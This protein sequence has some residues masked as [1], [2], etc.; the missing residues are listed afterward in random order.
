[1]G[2]APKDALKGLRTTLRDDLL[3]AFNEIVKTTGTSLG[4]LRAERR[5]VV[6]GGVHDGQGLARGWELP[7]E[8]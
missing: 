5:Q 4:T 7:E 1:M 8:G 6:R 3:Y 2:L